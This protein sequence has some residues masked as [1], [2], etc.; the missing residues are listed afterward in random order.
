MAVESAE[1]EHDESE[2]LNSV[3][4]MAI[5]PQY[6]TADKQPNQAERRVFDTKE[7]HTPIEPS[8]KAAPKRG[9]LAMIIIL[10]ILLLIAGA[11]GY[12]WMTGMLDLS[13]F[14]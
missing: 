11:V 13:K 9:S 2:D 7:Y 14:V 12:L 8:G 4:Q 3:R 1:P 10:V 5:T 6:Q